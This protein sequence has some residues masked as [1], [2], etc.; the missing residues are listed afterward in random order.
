MMH[1][2][3]VEVE[4]NTPSMDDDSR[5]HVERDENNEHILYYLLSLYTYHKL[6]AEILQL[7]VQIFCDR[8]NPSPGTNVPVQAAAATHRQC[9]NQE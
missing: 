6:I 3:V 4:Q 9:H 8:T 1:R 7:I 5:H 2:R